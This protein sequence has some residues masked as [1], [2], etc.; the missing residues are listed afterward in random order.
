MLRA[1]TPRRG[2]TGALSIGG[3][4][5]VLLDVEGT[6]GPVSFVRDV[7]FPYARRRID[8]FLSAHAGEPEVVRA[9]EEL[10]RVHQEDVREGRHPP[11]WAGSPSGAAYA[12]WLIDHDRKVT[13]LKTLQGLIWADGYRAGKLRAPVFDDV[14]PAFRRWRDAGIEIAIFSSG[15]VLAQRLYFEHTTQGDLT[16]FVRAYFDTSTGAKQDPESY[17]R[18]AGVLGMPPSQVVFVSDLEA[19]VGAA[20]EAG[21]GAAVRATPAETAAGPDRVPNLLSVGTP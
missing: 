8:R 10:H 6:V 12:R 21:M 15:S 14:V 7:L 4:R 9:L 16:P 18:I 5:L 2:E 19:E 3:A 13:P 1:S 20:R 11:L 17:R